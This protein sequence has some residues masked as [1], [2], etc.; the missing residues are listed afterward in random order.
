MPEFAVL[1]DMDGTMIDSAPYHDRAW[2]AT[3][4]E[5]GVDFTA[6]D[7]RRTFGWRNDSII[8]A[9]AGPDLPPE[10]VAAIATA[11]EERYRELVRQEGMVLLPGVGEWL[12]R[13]HARGIPQAIASSAP[14]E[15]IVTVLAVIEIAGFFQAVLSGDDVA[16]GKPDPALF[17]LAASRLGRSPATCVVVED[18][19]AGVEAARRA[20]MVCLAVTN[21]HP[22][23]R[24]AAAT[25][26]VDSLAGL[27]ED[28]F[29]R[30]SR[31]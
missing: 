17:L 12:E 16:Q 7:L 13:L 25:L 22:R 4:A 21:S 14:P 15:N 6:E 29:A 2:R 23:E 28:T 27:P 8:A 24:L 1:W 26:V 11:K 19:P 5:A 20:G 10:R 9:I 31:K 30:L 3:L 18:A